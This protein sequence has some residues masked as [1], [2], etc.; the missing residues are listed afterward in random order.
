MKETDTGGKTESLGMNEE[1]GKTIT[2]CIK[3]NPTDWFYG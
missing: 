2:K 3:K 1:I